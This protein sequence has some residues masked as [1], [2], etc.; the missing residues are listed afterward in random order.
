MNE[1][2]CVPR[3]NRSCDKCGQGFET[4]KPWARFCS[5]PCRTVWNREARDRRV[6]R[7]YMREIGRRGA[8]ARAAKRREAG[9]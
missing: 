7:E 1:S 4:R 3:M 9:A 5:T 2:G 6:I 8:A